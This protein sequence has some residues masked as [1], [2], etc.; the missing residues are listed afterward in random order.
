MPTITFRGTRQQLKD[1]LRSIPR[2]LAGSG[3]P[4]GIA[5]SIQLRAGVALLSKV[6]QAFI[7]KSRGGTG[8]DGIK[9][10]PLKRETIAQRRIGKGDL[11]GIGIKGAGQPKSRVRGLLTKDQDRRWRAIYASILARLRTQGDSDASGHAAA[12]AWTILKREGAQTK[13][14]VL[15]GRQV[16]ILR[17]TGELFRSLNPGVDDKPSGADG[18]IFQTPP[19]HVIIGTNKKTWHHAGIP[20]KLPARPLW[21]AALPDKWVDAIEK[22]ILR[23]IANAIIII[24]TKGGR[25]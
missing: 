9:W 21:P 18:Q 13:L 19:G 22:A 12:I 23:G 5:R 14:A 3:D 7:I 17:D 6:Q 11:Q 24:V 4:L 25:P 1:L 20:G 16:D 2:A 8:E 15:G 10:K